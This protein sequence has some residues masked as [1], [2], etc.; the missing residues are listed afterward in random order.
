M[1]HRGL[2][3]L[4]KAQTIRAYISG[5]PV[6]PCAFA[7]IFEFLYVGACVCHRVPLQTVSVR[8]C[9]FECRVSEQLFSSHPATSLH[10]QCFLFS[11]PSGGFSKGDQITTNTPWL[12]SSCSSG[13]DL[14]S[15][16]LN[17]MAINVLHN[18]SNRTA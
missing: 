4:L 3:A 2:R 9:V 5:T 15:F 8:V 18:N 14:F 17:I 16:C 10:A 12:V 11:V 13:H 6:A 7:L 1:E